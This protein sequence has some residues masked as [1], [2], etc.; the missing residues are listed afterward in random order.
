MHLA[1]LQLNK[2]IRI[3]PEAFFIMLGQGVA[4]LG[5]IFQIRVLTGFLPPAAYGELALALTGAVL[6]QQLILGPIGTACERYFAPSVESREL[7]IYIRAVGA[8]FAG[9]T[10][11]LVAISVGL[12]LVLWAVGWRSWLGILTPAFVFAWISSANSILDGVQNAARQRRIVAGHQGT[13]AWLRLGMILLLSRYMHLGCSGILWCF[14]ISYLLLICSQLFFLART[15]RR[16]GYVAP[17]SG[18][19]FRPLLSSMYRYAWPFSSWGIF[20]WIQTSSDRWALGGFAGFYELGLYQSLYQVGYYPISML[21][22]FL[23]QVCT[24][25]VF[26]RV[27]SGTDARRRQMAEKLNNT[28]T[29]IVLLATGIAAML[30]VLGGHKL[31][32]L[33]VA[34]AY[35]SHSSLISIFI[36]ASGCFAAGQIKALNLM[37]SFSTRQLIAPKVI[38]AAVGTALIAVGA[39][40]IGSNGVAAAQFVF[41]AFYLV[42]IFYLDG[43]TSASRLTVPEPM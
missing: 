24:P 7:G 10:L 16:L 4:A 19:S 28:L 34:P 39:Y 9:G 35:R 41:S 3:A 36:L 42:W 25:I 13:G 18:A 20:T 21:T 14:S 29:W 6:A 23:L 22:Q 26:Q 32:A 40:W 17:A 5:S 2:M 12:G 37:A 33:V 8:L 11:A 1:G 27:G 15:L 43:K 30:S 38:T 31:L